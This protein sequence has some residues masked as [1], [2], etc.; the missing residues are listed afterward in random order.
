MFSVTVR[1]VSTIFPIVPKIDYY[2]R[3]NQITEFMTTLS[4]EVYQQLVNPTPVIK[5]YF[6]T[7]QSVT[8]PKNTR[9]TK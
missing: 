9:R 3:V 2:I 5:Y 4:K 6:L 8:N 1:V 7:P